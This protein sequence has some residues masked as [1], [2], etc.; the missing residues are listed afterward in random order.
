MSAPRR[1]YL[2]CV[3]NISAEDFEHFAQETA[4]RYGYDTAPLGFQLSRYQFGSLSINWEATHMRR[5]YR[6]ALEIA[7]AHYDVPMMAAE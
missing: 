4:A 5:L 6:R 1:S 3:P 7:A 2:D